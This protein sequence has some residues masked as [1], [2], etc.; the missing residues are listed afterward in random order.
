M[1]EISN[2]SLQNSIFPY[3][4]SKYTTKFEAVKKGN[5]W[6]NSPQNIDFFWGCGNGNLPCVN[7]I[8]IDCFEN[9]FHLIPQMRS[10]NLKDGFYAKEIIPNE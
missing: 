6:Y 3:Q 10:T 4:N 1:L 9:Y 5:L 7:K 2:F 8:Q